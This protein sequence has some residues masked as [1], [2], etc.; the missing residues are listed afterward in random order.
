MRDDE[1]K[2]AEEVESLPLW[3]VIVHVQVQGEMFIPASTYAEAMAVAGLL[4]KED[5]HDLFTLNDGDAELVE[6]WMN[7]P[8]WIHE[9]N[10]YD[11]T[12]KTL[13]PE[14]ERY[15]AEPTPPDGEDDTD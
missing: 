11:P 5:P 6:A 15:Y 4:D 2:P 8:P 3:K 13:L 1:H 9:D 10:P 7:K 12:G 14:H